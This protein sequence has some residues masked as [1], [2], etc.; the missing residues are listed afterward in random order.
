MKV[1]E[2]MKEKVLDWVCA[3]MHM[4][5]RV[6]VCVYACMCEDTM[7]C[8]GREPLFLTG[9]NNKCLL[10]SMAFELDLKGEVGL[11]QVEE[12]RTF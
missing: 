7:G 6:C 4:C 11:S 2:A 10:K 3:G 12:R 5:V 9:K 8:T 1:T